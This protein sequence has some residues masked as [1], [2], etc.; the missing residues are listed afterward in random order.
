MP[1][2]KKHF[3]PEQSMDILQF[4]GK[5]LELTNIMMPSFYRERKAE[6][7]R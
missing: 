3:N 6:K 5:K 2:V 7:E 1:K 4:L